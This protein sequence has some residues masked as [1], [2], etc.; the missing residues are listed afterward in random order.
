MNAHGLM[1]R[2]AGVHPYYILLILFTIAYTIL[3]S[4][5]H[6]YDIRLIIEAMPSNYS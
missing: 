5:F 6:L 3:I 2:M 4:V 1:G